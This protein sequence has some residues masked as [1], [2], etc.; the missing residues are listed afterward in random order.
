MKK[1]YVS[2]IVL[3][4]VLVL[5]SFA[6]LWIGAGFYLPILSVLPLYFAVVTGIQHYSVV[7]SS[8][9]DPRTFVKN[10]LGINLGGLFLHLIVLCLWDFTH[11]ASAQ[12]FTLCFSICFAV[13]LIF[14]TAALILM[15][16]NKRR[17]TQQE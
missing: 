8:Y 9:K 7:Q 17:E 15:I 14:E 4:L 11:I 6:T 13:Y 10:F 5:V 3:T 12:K 2:I 16:R 1:Y